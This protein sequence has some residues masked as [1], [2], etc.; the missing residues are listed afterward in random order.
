MGKANI[1]TSEKVGAW[2]GPPRAARGGGRTPSPIIRILVQIRDFG[3]HVPK[4]FFLKH[5]F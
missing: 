3:R 4:V 1:Q 5:R 2:G